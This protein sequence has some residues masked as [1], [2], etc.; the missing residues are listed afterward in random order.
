M[1]DGR[2]LSG[3]PVQYADGVYCGAAYVYE[4]IATGVH[5]TIIMSGTKLLLGQNY[6][7][8]FHP[9]TQIKYTITEPGLVQL[10]IYDILGNRV[11]IP[12]NGNKQPGDYEIEFEAKGLH[13]GIYYYTLSLGKYTQTKKLVV[14]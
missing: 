3:A 8:P 7:N 6:P 9:A 12:V 5:E 10:A 4:G 14:K 2:V 13:P 11:A 1:D